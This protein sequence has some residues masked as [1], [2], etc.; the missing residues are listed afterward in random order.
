MGIGDFTGSDRG[1]LFCQ[2]PDKHSKC[3]KN[4]DSDA[5]RDNIQ[6]R[7]KLLL[8]LFNQLLKPTALYSKA[9]HITSG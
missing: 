7:H 8:E 2:S 4:G 9:K 1:S 5:Q 3:D 6:S